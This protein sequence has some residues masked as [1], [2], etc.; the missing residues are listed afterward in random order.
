MSSDQ[1]NPKNV[2]VIGAGPAGLS[3][4]VDLVDGG[5]KVTVVEASPY[6]GGLA[7]SFELWN[8]IVDVGPHRFF[9]N[10]ARINNHWRRFL[11]NKYS[12]VD[13]LTRI[14]YRNRFFYYP[15]KA[16]NVFSNLSLWDLGTSMLSYLA[17]KF[18]A[19]G[20]PKT[21]EDWVVSRFGRKLFS[22]FFKTYTEKVWGIPCAKLDADWAAQRIKKLS[23]WEA[24]KSAFIGN[25][26]NKHK[27]LVDQFAYPDE[28]AGRVYER[29]ADYLRSK[30]VPVMLSTPVAKVLQDQTGRV[31][32]VQLTNGQTLPA[33][34]VVSSMPLTN[35]VK[36]LQNVPQDVQE[37]CDWLY[38]RNTILVYLNVESADLFPDQWIYVHS[39]EVQHGRITNFRNWSP[40][41]YRDQKTSIIC[42][43]FWCFDR[44]PIWKMGD[45]ELG[46]LAEAE[47][48]LIR[49]I[50]AE[51]KVSASAVLKVPRSY[52]VY[53]TGYA[54]PLQKVQDYVDSVP[55]LLAIGRYGA[56][57]YNNQDHSILMGLLAAEQILTG[58]NKG[59]WA[60]NSDDEYQEGA[61]IQ[62]VSIRQDAQ[63]S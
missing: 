19:K 7:R 16:T 37:A 15:L 59:L 54:L 42:L 48:R 14:Y 57:K 24:V 8:Q 4:A 2:V 63:L 49:L 46:K 25:V 29:M 35:M 12:M 62:D 26:G 52:P 6:V 53:E 47:L 34:V 36:G 58:R 40:S 23:F 55:G 56:F 51:T 9:S 43:E 32:G 50:P 45:A 18:K 44:D 28:G 11:D 1:K 31:N 10:D 21:F 27:T 13:R 60:V 17:Q 30:S 20:E 33:D 61:K 38:Y 3:C 41:L 5:A 39:P 22:I